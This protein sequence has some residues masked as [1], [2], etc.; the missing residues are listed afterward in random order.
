MPELLR[1]IEKHRQAAL[2]LGMTAFLVRIS[3]YGLVDVP[4]GYHTANVVAQAFRGIAA[5]GLVMAA[6]GYGLHYLNGRSK[7]LGIV[8]DVSF[9]LYILH[10]APLTAA[11]YLLLNSGLS[12]WARWIIA[13][14]A[15][16][17]CVTLFTILARYVPPLRWLF[18]IRKPG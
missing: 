13:V 10:F 7:L 1:A 3:T 15:S 2:I 17:S 6:A 4:D 5:Y 9:P 8:R 16:W 11:V 12:V 18:G 14:A